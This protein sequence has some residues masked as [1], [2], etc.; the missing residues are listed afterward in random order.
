[1]Q[2]DII[3][4]NALAWAQTRLGQTRY[5]TLCLGFVEDA[6]ERGNDIQVDGYATAKEAADGYKAQD[7]SNV[8]P[9]GALVFYDW[10]GAINGTEKNWGHV[11]ISLGDGRVIHALAEV[12]ID[13]IRDVV[14]LLPP[15]EAHPSRYIGWV[16]TE[17]VLVGSVP[18][19]WPADR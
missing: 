5:A 4:A 14:A 13:P 1:M 18:R 7:D 2:T 8:P 19:V 9:R 3:I 16:P 10:W 12:R 17:V 6:Y 11:G 15:H